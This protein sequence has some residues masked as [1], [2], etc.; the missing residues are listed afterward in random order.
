MGANQSQ[1]KNEVSLGKVVAVF[2][3]RNNVTSLG[4]ACSL[5]R[6]HSSNVNFLQLL[7]SDELAYICSFLHLVDWTRLMS[8]SKNNFSIINESVWRE[9]LTKQFPNFNFAL[10]RLDCN[11]V[12]MSSSA[13]SASEK[14]NYY[15]IFL[16]DLVPLIHSINNCTC[17]YDP[18]T[19]NHYMKF[20]TGVDTVFDNI[21]HKK[22]LPSKTPEAIAALLRA[23]QFV[24]PIV[25]CTYLA[26]A[27]SYSRIECNVSKNF[28][29]N[30]INFTIIDFCTQVARRFFHKKFK[31]LNLNAALDFFLAELNLDMF[32][33]RS[34]Q[35]MSNQ[36]VLR[37]LIN[38]FGDL[39]GEEHYSA[40]IFSPL[41]FHEIAKLTSAKDMFKYCLQDANLMENTM[42]NKALLLRILPLRNSE[43][44]SYLCG[45]ERHSIVPAFVQ[46]FNFNNMFLPKALFLF[47]A[48]YS[49]PGSS[50]AND[51]VMAVFSEKYYTEN[52]T[53]ATNEDAIVVL[54]YGIIMLKQESLK[55]DKRQL[56]TKDQ[57]KK[58][59]Q[60]AEFCKGYVDQVYDFVLQ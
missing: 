58:N 41:H 15:S 3:K 2:L 14:F 6:H 31:N 25:I 53:V 28:G 9:F 19:T 16:H 48:H 49:I 51:H 39:F 11:T 60:E 7:A 56:I 5:E 18:F 1:Q 24:E 34:N 21:V 13:I 45:K 42:E 10:P 38:L 35:V 44:G 12:P 50:Q 17:E 43:V 54:V 46:S 27:S 36:Y 29:N 33:V 4:A 52:P 37:N 57:F 26:S 47:L 30:E 22:Y 23:C 8:T 32:S 20:L 59:F 55:Q 40:T